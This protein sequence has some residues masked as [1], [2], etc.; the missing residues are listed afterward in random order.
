[1]TYVLV[2]GCRE[3]AEGAGG[4]FQRPH[5]RERFMATR[6]VYSIG[7]LFETLY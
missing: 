3:W 2:V 7:L 4:A 1:V 6:Y 5:S